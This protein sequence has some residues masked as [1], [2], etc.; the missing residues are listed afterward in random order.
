MRKEFRQAED[1]LRGCV[2]WFREP[3]WIQPP[4]GLGVVALRVAGVQDGQL[5]VVGWNKDLTKT[6]LVHELAHRV[7][8]IYGGNP[9]DFV[10]HQMMERLG[11]L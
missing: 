9:P 11:V 8:Q 5:L 7:L 10:A 1:A 6:A 3:T 4:S 2:V